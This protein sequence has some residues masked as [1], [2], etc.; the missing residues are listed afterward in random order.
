MNYEFSGVEKV[1][2]G[3][4]LHRI[5]VTVDMSQRGVKAGDLGGLRE[6]ELGRP[7][8]V[9]SSNPKYNAD[10]LENIVRTKWLK[11]PEEKER[12]YETQQQSSNHG[13]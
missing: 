4:T 13:M 11:K 1:W 5:R 8:S 6:R 12:E 7:F 2:C 3:H 9:T 10:Y